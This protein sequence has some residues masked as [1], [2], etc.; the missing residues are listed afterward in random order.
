MLFVLILFFISFIN[1]NTKESDEVV[2]GEIIHLSSEMQA[3]RQNALSFKSDVDLNNES[4]SQTEIEEALLT[5]P[6]L[7]KYDTLPEQDKELSCALCLDSF[8]EL[9][10]DDQFKE[11][12]K[13]SCSHYFHLD[14]INEFKKNGKNDC[15]ICSHALDKTLAEIEIVDINFE[16]IT[17]GSLVKLLAE[18]RGLNYIISKELHTVKL[19]LKTYKTISIDRAWQIM[20]TLLNMH[21]FTHSITGSL[22]KFMTKKDGASENYP[23]FSSARGVTPEMLPD[24][25]QTIRYAYFLK[26]I[27]PDLANS[28]LGTLLAEKPIVVGDLDVIIM[29]DNARAIKQAMR[30]VDELDIGGMRKSVTILPLQYTD[31]EK[32]ASFLNDDLINGKNS[33]D[34]IRFLNP[35]KKNVTYFSTDVRIIPDKTKN[36]VILIGQQ[37]EIDRIVQFVKLAV[38]IG[39]GTAQSRVH[40][41]EVRYHKPDAIK[42]I[43]NKLKGSQPNS[44]ALKDAL[45][46]TES[47]SGGDRANVGSRLIVSCGNDDWKRISDFVDQIDKPSPTLA[48]EL[49]IVD[50]SL[51]MQRALSSHIRDANGGV[52]NNSIGIQANTNFTTNAV[53][54]SSR[55]INLAIPNNDDTSIATFSRTID[56]VVNSPWAYITAL[57][58][59]TNSAIIYQPFLSTSNN[60]LAHWASGEGRMDL[61]ELQSSGSQQVV[62]NKVEVTAK[63]IIDV[64]PRI[65]SSGTINLTLDLTIGEFSGNNNTTSRRVK[66]KAQLGLGEVLALGGFTKS[67]LS[68]NVYKVPIL[69]SIPILGNLFKSKTK[70]SVKTQLYVFVRISAIKQQL[71][72]EP[73]DYTALKI[74]YAKY[75]TDNVNT[76][77][78]SSDPIERYFFKPRK[79]S[80]KQTMNDFKSERFS[81][82][83]NFVENKSTPPMAD[84][85]SDPYY[86]STDLNISKNNLQ[87][88]W[89]NESSRGK[90]SKEVLL[91]KRKP[92][93]NVVLIK[94]IK[95]ED[96]GT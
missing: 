39:I 17:L 6:Q 91:K 48:I 51:N 73:D 80:I 57:A 13:T 1:L 63:T 49:M 41:K 3:P 87:D 65:N 74:K 44:D 7:F 72:S 25:D 82:I 68:S 55:E 32:V 23:F 28:V 61:G 16:T 66:T 50:A 30:I 10:T 4:I 26:N 52:L 46:H 8:S 69:S 96:L 79:S 70:S 89:S 86:N 71:H 18:K 76:Y 12:F 88:F 22:H 95:V 78:D 19:S 27:K 36:V 67:S 15:P 5:R 60:Q 54:S 64:T 59:Q 24:S 75:Q 90:A 40:I 92:I 9:E 43:L 77:A 81:Y 84:M 62:R 85:I 21:D 37:A 35:L 94:E 93:N 38:D 42:N 2:V 34:R 58:K 29:K 83:D 33:T 20:L 53:N 31:A 47:S 56:G 11:I 14:C 45:I